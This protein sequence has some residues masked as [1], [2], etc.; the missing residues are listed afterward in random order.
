M[1]LKSAVRVSKHCKFPPPQTLVML[2]KRDFGIG[3]ANKQQPRIEI[4]DSPRQQRTVYCRFGNMGR[5]CVF[6]TLH[7]LQL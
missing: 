4:F 5:V 1:R 7:K 3:S 2:R 6:F